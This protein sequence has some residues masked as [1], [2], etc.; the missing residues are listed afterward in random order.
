[1]PINTPT[2]CN[3]MEDI[4]SLAG[5]YLK[6]L[7]IDTFK[8]NYEDSLNDCLINQ[9]R[10]YRADSPEAI[11]FVLEAADNKWT[12]ESVLL[13]IYENATGPLFL[14]ND[15]PSGMSEII[16]GNSSA[17]KQSICE[18]IDVNRELSFNVLKLKL[19]IFFCF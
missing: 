15:N 2:D 14:S 3:I 9:M 13:H 11:S 8:R 12:F 10:L 16:I 5:V 19:N 6:S 1:M 7:C 18:Y 4:Y 17:Y